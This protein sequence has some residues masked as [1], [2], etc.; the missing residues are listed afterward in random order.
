MPSLDASLS[1]WGVAKVRASER[2][3]AVTTKLQAATRGLLARAERDR[4]LVALSTAPDDAPA[5]EVLLAHIAHSV[6]DSMIVAI[7]ATRTPAAPPSTPP[8]A[9]GWANEAVYEAAAE[10]AAE[11]AAEAVAEVVVMA[12]VPAQAADCGV[13]S[14]KAR[15]SAW[16]AAKLRANATALRASTALQASTR[17]MLTRVKAAQWQ[18]TALSLDVSEDGEVSMAFAPR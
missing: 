10:T 2:L 4:E 14:S 15:P 13:V 18:G 12:T 3:L 11:T 1:T 16:A 7:L 17:G 9:D 6:V 8:T 5:T